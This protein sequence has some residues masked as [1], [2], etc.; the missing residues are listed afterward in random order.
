MSKL[1]QISRQDI[2]WEGE[3]LEIFP[4]TGNGKAGHR[5]KKSGADAGA[6]AGKGVLVKGVSKN[7]LPA[8]RNDNGR[9]QS[10]DIK[11]LHTDT[12]VK[13]V[14]FCNWEYINIIPHLNLT[15]PPPMSNVNR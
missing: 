9:M 10:G 12:L 13:E 3:N 2:K 8:A 6:G 11:I 14:T 1:F 4:E 5:F 15:F 7:E